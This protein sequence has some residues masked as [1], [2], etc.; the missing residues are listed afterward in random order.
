MMSDM[1][2]DEV[3]RMLRLKPLPD[4]GGY[5]RETYRSDETVTVPLGANR[6]TFTR[7]LATQIYY[8]ITED[9]FSALHRIKH[10]EIFH[11]YAGLP[12]EMFLISPDGQAR[13]VMLGSDLKGKQEPQVI[14]KRD[15]WQGLRLQSGQKGWSLMGTSVSPGFDYADF[16]VGRRT[17]LL[18]EFTEFSDQIIRYTRAD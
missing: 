10:D 6:G 15:T 11:H 8:L 7:N 3:I 14:V 2:A 9:N 16:E 12:A 1:S 18:K 17:A 13:T 4:E 5:F